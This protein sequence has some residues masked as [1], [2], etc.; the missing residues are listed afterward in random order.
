M[1]VIGVYKRTYGEESS[2]N[3]EEEKTGEG[4]SPGVNSGTRAKADYKPYVW[5]HPPKGIELN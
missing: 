2:Y 5:I 1:V 3:A 4:K